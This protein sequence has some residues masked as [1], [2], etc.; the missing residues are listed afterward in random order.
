MKAKAFKPGDF[1]YINHSTVKKHG[2]IKSVGEGIFE[3][4]FD[5]LRQDGKKR[6]YARTSLKLVAKAQR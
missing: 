4:C 1:V 6:N 2:I 3:G 5:V